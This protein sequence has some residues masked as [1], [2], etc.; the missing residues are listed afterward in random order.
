MLIIYIILKGHAG[1]G[2]FVIIY[3]REE[4]RI[5]G[6]NE[7]RK[8]VQMILIV[9]QIALLVS[10]MVYMYVAVVKIVL[11]RKKRQ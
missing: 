10:V 5:A 8:I 2:G 4:W 9:I 11:A 3:L 6:Q 7:L 1:V